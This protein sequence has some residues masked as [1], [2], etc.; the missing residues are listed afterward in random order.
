MNLSDCSDYVAENLEKRSLVFWLEILESF[1]LL[2][3][4]FNLGFD[5]DFCLFFDLDDDV[6]INSLSLIDWLI[7]LENQRNLSFVGHGQYET[8]RNIAIVD[9]ITV[10]DSMEP[11]ILLIKVH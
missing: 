11:Q 6:R 5:L 3:F 1:F 4:R 9:I 10:S 2:L 8:F 7:E